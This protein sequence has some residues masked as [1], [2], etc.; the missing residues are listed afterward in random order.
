MHINKKIKY[1]AAVVFIIAAGVFYVLISGKKRNGAAFETSFEVAET[2]ADETVTT[3]EET[4][5]VYVCGCVCAPGVVYPKCGD[6][7]CDAINMAGG[8]TAEADLNLINQAAL[9]KD[10]QQLYIPAEG[11]N[12]EASGFESGLINLNTAGKEQ[13]MTLPG[14]GE[15]RALS[16]I[17][18]REEKGD[19]F[20][21]SDIMKVSG[22]KE[23][24]FEKL[25]DLVCV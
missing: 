17:A 2:F 15:S 21:I 22:I 13:L 14:I 16:I 23:A 19:F 9:L 5:C 7:V 6:R 18:Y 24:A 25:K 10:G 12:G 20:E 1:A 4:L 3:E 8:L 11:E